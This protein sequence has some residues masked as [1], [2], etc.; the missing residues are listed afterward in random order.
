MENVFDLEVKVEEDG[1][2]IYPS[3]SDAQARDIY[4]DIALYLD[5]YIYPWIKSYGSRCSPSFF[6]SFALDNFF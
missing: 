4:N 3:L 2:A 6:Y 1:E 5:G